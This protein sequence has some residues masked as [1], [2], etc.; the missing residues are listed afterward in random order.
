MAV[1]THIAE[2]TAAA[3]NGEGPGQ[4]VQTAPAPEGLSLVGF[5]EKE[6]K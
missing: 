5:L 3:P 6:E 1:S 2:A 4:T